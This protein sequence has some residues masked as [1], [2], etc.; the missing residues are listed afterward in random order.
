M[1][2]FKAGKRTLNQLSQVK[3][4]ILSFSGDGY[5]LER[6]NI[7][8]L[9]LETLKSIMIDGISSNP[10]L[11]DYTLKLPILILDCCVKILSESKENENPAGNYDLVKNYTYKAIHLYQA[12][13]IH[14][15]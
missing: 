8:P 12:N 10:Y 7:F 5:I 4:I 13:C 2:N 11:L 1:T 14:K 6:K 15:P 9:C 3:E